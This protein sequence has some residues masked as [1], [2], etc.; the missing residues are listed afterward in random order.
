MGEPERSYFVALMGY[1]PWWAEGTFWR[2]LESEW[3][4]FDAL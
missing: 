1:R 2:L 3:W 4:E